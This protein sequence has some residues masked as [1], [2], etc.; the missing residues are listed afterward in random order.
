MCVSHV[1]LQ[2]TRLW[3]GRRLHFQLSAAK[4]LA[5]QKSRAENYVLLKFAFPRTICE[6]E[7]ATRTTFSATTRRKTCVKKLLAA[8]TSAAR[9][10]T[11]RGPRKQKHKSVRSMRGAPCEPELVNYTTGSAL[12]HTAACQSRSLSPLPALLQ[13]TSPPCSSPTPCLSLSRPISL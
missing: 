9:T 12:S 8:K 6:F 5:R 10:R 1:A 2:K 13:R 7:R 4:H 3:C 11:G